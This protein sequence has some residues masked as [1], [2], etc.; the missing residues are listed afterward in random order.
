MW[1]IDLF[2]VGREDAGFNHT[3]LADAGNK[4][5]STREA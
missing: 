3:T 1:E 2:D 5:C 4:Y